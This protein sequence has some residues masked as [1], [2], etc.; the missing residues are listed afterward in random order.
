MA[1]IKVMVVDDSPFMQRVLKKLL[2]SD[3]DIEVIETASD[4]IDMLEKLKKVRPDVITLD[5]EMPKMDGLKALEKIMEM[6]DPIPVIMV[7][8]LTTEGAETTLKALELGAIDFI[9]KPSSMFSLSMEK[10]K[11]D[12]I[13][14]VKTAAKVDVKLI[15]IKRLVEATRKRVIKPKKTEE[16][17]YDVV[18]IGISTGGPPALQRLLPELPKDLPTGI[19]IAQH[20]PP[21]FTKSLAERL[22]RM[23]S[24]EVKEA[25]DG[26]PIKPGTVLIGKAGYH[27]K[28][29]KR[30]GKHVVRITEEPKDALYHPSVD[31]M[32]ESALETFDY[33]KV[34]AIIMTGMGS[35]G[36]KP[37]KKMKEKGFKIIAE[38]KETCAIF[39]MPRAAIETGCV[40]RIVPLYDMAKVIVE[41]VTGAAPEIEER[42]GAIA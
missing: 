39:G 34:L 4:G 3:P 24:I 38:S 11:D 41:E 30:F 20:M 13:R 2:E 9:P 27:V 26:D 12:L 16:K 28:F 10:I 6:K 23:S 40:D 21:G 18:L 8:S 17:R 37:L 14:K 31:V 29:R 15:K 5:V 33:G 19:V 22:N 42:K 1:K 25:D 32:F 7:S 35:D 36:S